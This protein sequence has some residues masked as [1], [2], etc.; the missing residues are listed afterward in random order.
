MWT[1]P[2]RCPGRSGGSDEV[3][4]NVYHVAGPLAAG[5]VLCRRD[6]S[7]SGFFTGMPYFSR[8]GI[9][10]R[11]TWSRNM[12]SFATSARATC[13]DFDVA[14]AVTVWVRENGLIAA[15]TG[16]AMEAFDLPISPPTRR[17]SHVYTLLSW[18]VFGLTA[19]FVPMTRVSGR[20]CCCSHNPLLTRHFISTSI[21]PPVRP[22]GISPSL[23]Q[24]GE[25]L[26]EIIRQSFRYR[27][28]RRYRHVMSTLQPLHHRRVP[29][30]YGRVPLH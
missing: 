3:V 26:G 29:L 4:V 6:A 10:I 30:R 17:H 8:L 16:I 7:L 11:C 21:A 25:L 2:G 9:T 22:L 24:G 15:A 27:Q 12:I 28:H 19:V 1:S 14:T 20:R 23:L 18:F 5:R 13:F